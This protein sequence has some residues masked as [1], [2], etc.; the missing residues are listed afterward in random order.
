V[1]GDPDHLDA[2]ARKLRDRADDVR[3]VAS[4]H[5][6]A[7]S[8]ARWVS[9]SAEAY[10]AEVYGDQIDANAAADGMD[11]AAGL[12]NA[13]AQ[14]VR[15]AIA[16]IAAA[17][18]AV[19]DFLGRAASGAVEVAGDVVDGVREGAESLLDAVGRRLPDPGSM[20]WSDL[21]SLLPWED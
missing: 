6:K 16:M 3:A 5:M 18:A 10:R 2:L 1:Y 14:E 17:E 9:D 19:R 11:L 15:E 12:L 20:E 21:K 7:A 8:N 13:H 4:E